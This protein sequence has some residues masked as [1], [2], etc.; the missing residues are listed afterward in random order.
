MN[1]LRK[2]FHICATIVSQ[3]LPP[4]DRLFLKKSD[5]NKK[6]FLSVLYYFLISFIFYDYDADK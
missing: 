3:H 6:A 1:F 4:C 5:R 2:F